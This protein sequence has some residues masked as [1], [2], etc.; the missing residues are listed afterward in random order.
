M[1]AWGKFKDKTVALSSFLSFLEHELTLLSASMAMLRYPVP[2]ILVIFAAIFPKKAVTDSPQAPLK[3]LLQQHTYPTAMAQS[4]AR[5]R[6]K[7]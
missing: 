6:A 5:T 3:R 4:P 1:L 2:T 7:G